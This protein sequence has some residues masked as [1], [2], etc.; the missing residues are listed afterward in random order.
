MPEITKQTVMNEISDCLGIARHATSSGSTEPRAFFDD[1]ATAIGLVPEKYRTKQLLAEALARSLG[2]SWD[3]TCD[4]REHAHAGGGTV[5]LEGLQRIWRGL[6]HLMT[7]RDA[8]F[9]MKVAAALRSETEENEPPPGNAHPARDRSDSTGFQRS[10]EVARWVRQ[11]AQ[12]VC[13]LCRKPAPF[14]SRFGQPYLEVHHVQPLAEGGP[15]TVENAIALCPN[16]HRCA[17]LSTETD[18]IRATLA[19]LVRQSPYFREC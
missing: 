5:S 2:E 6:R 18:S 4:S 3:G 9:E 13:A 12:G 8:I 1:V 11:K 19:E 15:D 7:T 14:V 10:L 17:H 16:C